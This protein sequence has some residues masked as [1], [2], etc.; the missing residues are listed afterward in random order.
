MTSGLYYM[1]IISNQ[2]I[3][4]CCLPVFICFMLL[5]CQSITSQPSIS[6][7]FKLNYEF[8]LVF[9]FPFIFVILFILL[10]FSFPIISIIKYGYRG[11]E[12]FF[13]SFRFVFVSIAGRRLGFNLILR[14]YPHTGMYSNQTTCAISTTY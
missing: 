7:G 9:P 12:R 10:L 8:P 14:F 2:T 4:E 5:S 1:Y 13:R 3:M 11:R 6:F